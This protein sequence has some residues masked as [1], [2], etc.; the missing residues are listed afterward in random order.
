[1]PAATAAGA[2]RKPGM[3]SRGEKGRRRHPLLFLAALCVITSASAVPAQPIEP[4]AMDQPIEFKAD[5]VT[6]NSRNKIMRATG[7]VEA[8]Q[9]GRRLVADTVL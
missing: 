5:E 1:M 9:A 6:Y 8:V 7:N 2:A 3:S 4:V